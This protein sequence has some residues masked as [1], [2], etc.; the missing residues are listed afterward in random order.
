MTVALVGEGP[1][2]EAVAAA[3]SD[4]AAR[5]ATVDP[6]GIAGADLAVVVAECG[7]S[8]FER[9]GET[10][11]DD[12]VPWLAVEIGG[13][14]DH[15]V[16]AASVAGFGPDTGCRHC[17]QARVASNADAARQP[18]EEQES[19][20]PGTARFAGA[21]AGREAVRVL[22]GE[23]QILGG[24][25][26]LPHAR[27]QFYAVPDCA[28]APDRDR[29]LPVS[30]VDRSVADALDRAETTLD[31]RVGLVRETGEVESFPLPYYLATLA[32][33]S[34]FSDAAAG[35]QAAGADPD[36]NVGFVKALGEALERY[37]A[38]VYR[39]DSFERAQPDGVENPVP[40]SRF[41]TPDEWETPD[42]DAALRWVP[43]RN[44]ATEEMVNLPAEFVQ[45]PP[46]DE[47]FRP[48]VTT[49][50][51]LG[52]GSVEALRSGLYE[53]VERDAAMLAWYSTFE[54]L[55]L[56]VSDEGFETLAARARSE[57]LTI[58]PVVLTQDIDVPVV[59][60]GVTRGEWPRFAVGTGAHLDPARAA[61]DALSEALQN[62][63]ELR[64]MGPEAAADADGAIGRYAADPGE[65]GAFL[66]P[67][68]TVPAASVGPATVPEGEGHLEAVVERVRA[69]ELDVYAA[70]TTT[71]D[72]A[73]AGFE[74]V[75]VL[76]PGAQPLCF[77]GQ[78]FGERATTVPADLGFAT[79]T[80]RAH[81]PYP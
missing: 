69:A 10:A 50:L 51:G 59:G 46:P 16:V 73:A 21:L 65:A 19:P 4:V 18:G 70:R 80:D 14:A 27:R 24:V 72:V 57:G 45:F 33:T 42:D 76:V 56:D 23:G 29:T 61:R 49:G 52:S 75:R 63:T 77:G 32:D 11:R 71:R 38:G 9:A 8:A 15:P 1:A 36:W 47:R 58:Q 31:E 48:A 28:C 53:V 7:A 22:E 74:G 60:V 17:L 20:G 12:G 2:R 66:D 43:G 25:I 64:G 54:P 37:C 44:L 34:G 35:P 40:P 6:G 5:V 62:W 67:A 41:V 68:T 13:L 26:E 79:R 30:S 39:A 55:G 81:H 3:L 78:Y